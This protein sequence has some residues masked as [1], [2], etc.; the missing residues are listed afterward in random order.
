MCFTPWM[1]LATAIIE[2]VLATILILMFK[3]TCL[4]DF[5]AAFIY[6]LGAYQLVEFFLC[7]GGNPA[8]WAMLGFVIYS[9]L[10]AVGLHGVLTY[11]KNKVN[12]AFLYIVPVVATIFAFGN[13]SFI[14]G[15]NC[16]AVF[17]S[18]DTI[19]DQAIFQIPLLLYVLYY[20]GFIFY[21]CVILF[22]DFR[23]E[24]SKIRREIDWVLGIGLFLMVVPTL[25]FIIVFPLLKFSFPSVLCQFALFVSVSAFTAVYLES[26]TRKPRP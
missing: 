19:L 15:A 26:K 11:T 21:A 18:V 9:Y 5:F 7:T 2:F 20:F 4:R 16:D 24:R 25:V 23:E 6:L 8:F 3:R 22:N 14:E 12:L 1:S 13:R 10:P 17:I